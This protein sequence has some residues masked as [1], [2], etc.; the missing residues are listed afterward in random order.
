MQQ[1][2]LGKS[3][4]EVSAMGLGCWGMS[5]AYGPADEA[6]SI[7]TLQHALDLGRGLSRPAAGGLDQSRGEPVLF[8]QQDLEQVL[9]SELLMPACE[10]E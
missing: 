2:S 1:R 7:A 10:R 8:L 4:I 6:E 9:W 3:G 5:G